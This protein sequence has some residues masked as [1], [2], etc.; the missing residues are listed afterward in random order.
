VLDNTRDWGFG[1]GVLCLAE[2]SG[3]N[4]LFTA[5]EN[6]EEASNRLAF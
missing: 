4:T 1:N 6:F 3:N 2:I 5:S